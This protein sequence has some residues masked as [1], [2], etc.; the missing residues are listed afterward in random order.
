MTS[1]LQVR[2]AELDCGLYAD[3]CHQ[4]GVDTYPTLIYY[5]CCQ[6]SVLRASLI[7]HVLNML[8]TV[9]SGHKMETY[10]EPRTFAELREFVK[11]LVHR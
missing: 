8:Q 11:R 3:L 9:R 5:R 4:E 7:A 2:I 1:P 6:Y 10:R